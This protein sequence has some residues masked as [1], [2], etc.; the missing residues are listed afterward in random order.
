MLVALR[1]FCVREQLAVI[2][3]PFHGTLLWITSIVF[4]D[5]PIARCVAINDDFSEF[6]REFFFAHVNKFKVGIQ[7]DWVFGC[8]IDGCVILS[9]CCDFKNDLQLKRRV[10][11]FRASFAC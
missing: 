3:I 11:G 10:V 7:T 6:L 4:Y 1:R 8:E 9:K 5:A 2:G